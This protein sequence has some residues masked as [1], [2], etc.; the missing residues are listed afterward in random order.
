MK[1]HGLYLEC[2][3]SKK[4]NTLLLMISTLSVPNKG[5]SCSIWWEL[6]K[7]RS[8]FNIIL[9]VCLLFFTTL[10]FWIKRLL[11]YMHWFHCFLLLF[12]FWNVSQLLFRCRPLPLLERFELY[13]KKSISICVEINWGLLWTYLIHDS[14]F[15][16]TTIQVYTQDARISICYS[17]LNKT[18]III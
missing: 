18:T 6:V 16:K 12:L 4:N 14:N 13:K 10:W 15:Q 8:P 1:P 5:G 3:A 9:C 11:L 7:K 17:L 2:K